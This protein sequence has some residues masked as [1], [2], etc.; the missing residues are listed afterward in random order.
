MLKKFTIIAAFAAALGFVANAYA[1]TVSGRV[2]NFSPTSISVFDKEIVTVGVNNETVFTKL[3]TAKPWQEN[4]ALTANA[5]RVGAF[6][7]VHVPDGNGFV[8]NW[9][10]VGDV[11]VVNNVPFTATPALGY[12]EEGLKHLAEANA[13]RANPTA[14]ESKR[15]G[16]VDTALHCERMAALNRS[17][18]IAAPVTNEAPVNTE[19]AKHRAEAAKLRANPNASESK[20]PGSPGTAVHCDRLAAE[21]EKAGK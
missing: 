3:I 9:V 6:V 17:A 19:A 2:T 10:Q 15:P 8:A 16:A 4:T 12:T 20:R 7:V 14:S 1:S 18:A 13:R 21:L 5:L 11:R